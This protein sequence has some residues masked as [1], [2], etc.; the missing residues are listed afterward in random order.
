MIKKYSYN[1]FAGILE[2]EIDEAICPRFDLDEM[3]NRINSGESLAI[4][5]LGRK[6]RGKSTHLMWLQQYLDQ[7]PIFSLNGNTSFQGILE[8]ESRI[9]FVDSIHHL[10]IVERVAL[11][12]AK[13]TVIYTTHFN[14]KL[15][16]L[17]AKKK[18]FC[19]RFKGINAVILT[20]ILN[21]RLTLAATKIVDT[22]AV[23]TTKEVQALIR[24]FGDD[25]RAIINHLYQEFQCPNPR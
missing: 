24:K 3:V 8:H 22:E 17:L 13:K 15:E 5:F 19:I 20:D 18:R 23:F 7:Y 9:I 10:N 16:C 25:Y 6:G 11:F 1:P 4:E 12:R 14:R 2:E 21:K